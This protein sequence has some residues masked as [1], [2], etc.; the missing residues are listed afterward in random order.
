MEHTQLGRTG[1]EVSRICLGC[2]TYGAPDRGNHSRTLPED[3]SLPLIR[4]ALDSDV[5]G[6][7]LCAGAI[8]SDRRVIE[9]VA[10]VAKQRGVSRAQIALAWVAQKGVVT[11]P[12][13]GASRPHHLDDAVAALSLKLTPDE[14]AALEEPYAPHS[15]VGFH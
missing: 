6:K 9:R 8:E 3:R 12:I 7:S 14:T 2:M 5:F 15:V 13:V 10:E 4:K 11:A 1:L